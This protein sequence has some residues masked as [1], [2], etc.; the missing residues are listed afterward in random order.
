MISKSRILIW[1]IRKVYSDKN[2]INEHI[3]T[4][5]NQRIFVMVTIL[6]VASIW[7]PKFQCM[8]SLCIILNKCVSGTDE[9]LQFKRREKSIIYMIL[10]IYVKSHKETHIISWKSNIWRF[11]VVELYLYTYWILHTC[12]YHLLK[13]YLSKYL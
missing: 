2:T 8:L 11:R 6:Y 13:T 9:M 7:P 5:K 12:E 4:K 1:G 3:E 10:R